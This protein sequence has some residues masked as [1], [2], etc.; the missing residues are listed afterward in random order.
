MELDR[1]V[2]ER[3]AAQERQMEEERR[4][5][6]VEGEMARAREAERRKREGEAMMKHMQEMKLRESELAKERE[7]EL[8]AMHFEALLKQEAEK[9]E[10][11]KLLRE[12]Q[13][14]LQEEYAKKLQG[15]YDAE[16]QKLQRQYDEEA[17]TNY[18][19]NMPIGGE[20]QGAAYVTTTNSTL[21]YNP[22]SSADFTSVVTST[23]GKKKKG[24]AGFAN[25]LVQ[26]TAHKFDKAYAL[27][28]DNDTAF[29]QFRKYFRF[30]E[31]EPL[32][33]E[34]PCKFASSEQHMMI[35]ALYITPNYVCFSGELMNNRL[36]VILAYADIESIEEGVISL[37]Q[38]YKI[39]P[40]IAPAAQ[41]SGKPNALLILDSRGKLH[42]LY[43]FSDTL[44]AYNT[45][46]GVWSVNP[47]RVE[48][49]NQRAQ[50]PLKP[51]N[52]GVAS[53]VAPP[54]V[55]WKKQSQ[56][57]LYSSQDAKSS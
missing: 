38:R 36:S 33:G 30:R 12:E 29:S 32:Y 37:E 34:F 27:V 15:Q 41:S 42:R 39:V 26:E 8:E 43:S 14:K 18:F 28:S 3:K 53:P 13:L 46:V 48:R 20:F 2:A 45:L 10:Y 24:L 7:K 55:P 44:K 5:R 50:P 23:K 1:Q 52:V 56:T 35:G 19:P 49:L 47:L 31:Y 22:A 40:A 25:R 54:P 21:S 17:K 51:S 4:K 16:A 6:E 11:E 57:W 9:M